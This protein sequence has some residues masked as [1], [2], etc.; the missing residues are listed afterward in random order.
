MA[1][2]PKTKTDI[3]SMMVQIQ[4]Q[5]AVMNEK[6][7]SFMTKS[8]TELAQA[9]A[10]SKPVHRPVPTPSPSSPRPLEHQG[11]PMFTVICF[12]CGNDCEVPFK[13]SGTRPV[14]CKE[15]WA[16]RKAGRG[17]QPPTSSSAP[18]TV[19]TAA[20]D[21]IDLAMKKPAPKKKSV[22][23][24]KSAGKKKT[25]VKKKAKR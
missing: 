9:L 16:K 17:P 4:E 6:L 7:D 11:R 14:Y 8:L 15:C 18:A 20:G 10:A 12:D 13:P 25:N 1:K 23:A 5:L 3:N 2:K 19:K 22:S 21:I 24:K